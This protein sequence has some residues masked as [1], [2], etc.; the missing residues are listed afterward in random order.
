MTALD[1]I[2]L[3][4]NSTRIVPKV[5][6]L[7][8]TIILSTSKNSYNITYHYTITLHQYNIIKQHVISQFIKLLSL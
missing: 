5:Q 6:K 4:S 2:E 3:K 1:P 7:T 8:N